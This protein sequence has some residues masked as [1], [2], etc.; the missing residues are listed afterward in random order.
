MIA[1][2]GRESSRHELP[3]DNI[4]DETKSHSLWECSLTIASSHETVSPTLNIELWRRSISENQSKCSSARPP[5]LLSWHHLPP[6]VPPHRPREHSLL[7]GKYIRAR[8]GVA[9]QNKTADM[10]I[11]AKSVLTAIGISASTA[12]SEVSAARVL[13]RKVYGAL[14]L[15]HLRE[16][17]ARCCWYTIQLK[18]RHR[19]SA[20]QRVA[21]LG[22]QEK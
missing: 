21:E 16:V 19:G 3:L 6:W 20:P 5:S 13:I 4:K 18:G 1:Y 8:N 12:A 7:V 17:E 2:R 15:K 9:T 11:D 14:A 22:V 10:I